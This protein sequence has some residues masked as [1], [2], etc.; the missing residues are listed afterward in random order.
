MDNGHLIVLKI[1]GIE[2]VGCSLCVKF[3]KVI[4]SKAGHAYPRMGTMTAINIRIYIIRINYIY[5]LSICKGS[6]PIAET[7]VWKKIHTTNFSLFCVQV[8]CHHV[9]NCVIK[10]G[11]SKVSLGTRTG[12]RSFQPRA[13]AL[14]IEHVACWWRSLFH[15]W[16]L[17]GSGWDWSNS[18]SGSRCQSGS[19]Y[20]LIM[21]V[22]HI[23]LALFVGDPLITSLQ[24]TYVHICIPLHKCIE[25]HRTSWNIASIFVGTVSAHLCISCRRASFISKASN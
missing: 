8:T 24:R 14:N 7:T 22:P 13:L 16:P 1:A 12:E 18:S 6:L 17:L 3:D 21:F 10:Y 20:S 23:V 4:S 2:H 11:E 9:H 19:V 15:C 5:I 25:N